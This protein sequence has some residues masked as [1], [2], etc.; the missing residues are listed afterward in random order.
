MALDAGYV[1][2]PP[3]AAALYKSVGRSPL[4][5]LAAVF[6]GVSA[7][8]SANLL[9]TGLDPMLAELT[10]LGAR[11][12]DPGYQVAATCNWWFMIASTF[13]LTLVGWA[14]TA[15]F[16][17]PRYALK[18]ADEGGPSPITREDTEAKVITADEKRGLAAAGKVLAVFF[19]LLFLL[20]NP[21]A[22]LPYQPPLQG[23]AGPFPKWVASIVPL[24]FFFFLLPGLAYGISSKTIKSDHDVA[25]MI[26]S[27]SVPR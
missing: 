8:F 3:I 25:K 6:V 15:W 1:V 18:T 21:G 4:V 23:D 10:A 19:V 16:V 20:I 24:L 2:L 9:I 22:I 13:V 26:P 14:V 12:I 7:G 5:G 17:E 11:N 27:R